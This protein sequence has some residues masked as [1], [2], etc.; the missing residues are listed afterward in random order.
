[1]CLESARLFPRIAKEDIVVCKKLA[2]CDGKLVTW[3][4]DYPVTNMIMKTKFIL[5]TIIKLLFKDRIHGRY[6]IEEGFIHSYNTIIFGTELGEFDGYTMC[7]KA[8]IP[9]GALYYKDYWG[10]TYA[11]NKLILKP[12][13]EQLNYFENK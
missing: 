6:N 4:R 12:S 10:S 3:Y 2:Y 7:V 11:S 1:M 13:E 8:I 5:F 9:K